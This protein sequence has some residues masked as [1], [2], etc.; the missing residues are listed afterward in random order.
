MTKSKDLV[1]MSGGLS[2]PSELQDFYKDNAGVGSENLAGSM[3]QLKIT[4]S[5][6]QNEGVDGQYLAA[7][8]FYYSPT[9]EAFSTVRVAIMAISRGFYAMDNQK[10][11]KPKFTQLLS[12]MMLD[13]LQPFVMFISGTRLQNMWNFGKEIKPF[14]KQVPMFSFEV[15]LGLDKVKTDF[16]MN[17]V[18]TY[19]IK[20]DGKGQIQLLADRELLNLLR[21]GVDQAEDM[22]DSFINQ[23][24]VDRIT[25]KLLKD[26]DDLAD[27]VQAHVVDA[28]E[29][30]HLETPPED[31]VPGQSDDVTDDIPF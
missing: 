30:E 8:Q 31:F 27:A 17:H 12:G 2:I 1:T 4:E 11:P 10:E 15:E 29:E 22:F 24:E 26:Q 7:G 13:T 28:Q 25:G 19:T 20:R 14:T 9:K 6:S 18:V 5:N 16:G 23:K 21:A 3:P